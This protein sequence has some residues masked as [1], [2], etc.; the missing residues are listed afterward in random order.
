[1]TLSHCWG[2]SRHFTT[3]LETISARKNGI[4]FQDL[5]KTFQDAVTLTRHIGVRYLWLDSICICQDD[6]KDWEG[7]SAEMGTVYSNS[8]LNIAASHAKDDTFGCFSHRRSRR[9]LELT[10]HNNGNASTKCLAFALALPKAISSRHYIALED[11]PLADRAWVLQERCLAPRTLH[12][13]TDQ[14]YFE[15]CEEML[16]EDGVQYTGRY[17]GLDAHKQRDKVHRP[18]LELRSYRAWYDLIQ[19]YGCRKL[20][21]SS[22]KLPALAGLA[23]RFQ[24]QLGDEYCA[25]LWRRQLIE[26]LCWEVTKEERDRTSEPAEYRAPSWSWASIDGPFRVWECVVLATVIECQIKVRGLNPFGEVE[27]ARLKL[28]APLEPLIYSEEDLGGL[29]PSRRVGLVGG[30]KVGRYPKCDTKSREHNLHALP[31]FALFIGYHALEIPRF[32]L[33]YALI[34]TPASDEKNVFRRLGMV[35]M[36]EH[37]VRD[38]PWK[39]GGEE[40]ALPIITL[41]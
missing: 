32:T 28:R 34:V 17:H 12:Y 39:R 30:D 8:Y 18:N 41:V 10:M 14:M 31:L 2:T 13:A 36:L 27:E 6:A 29:P 25:G 20:S 7:T 9:H 21:K 22:D 35:L 3:T 40:T 4:G 38:L 1:M 33:Y 23:R 26:G 15:C 5:P 24:D 16:S 11:E 19:N 37:D